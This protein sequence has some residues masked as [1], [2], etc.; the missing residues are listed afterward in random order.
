MFCFHFLEKVLFLFPRFSKR[1]LR[2]NVLPCELK[3]CS[4]HSFFFVF[5]KKNNFVLYTLKNEKLAGEQAKIARTGDIK[6][7]YH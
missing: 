1:T 2:K 4:F 6:L 7:P 3:I 5:R